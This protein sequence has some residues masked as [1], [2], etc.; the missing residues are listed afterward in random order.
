MKVI[1]KLIS[2]TLLISFSTLLNAAE[3]TGIVLPKH[4][5]ELTLPID[6]KISEL[7]LKEGDNISKE[8]KILKLDDSLQVL[9]TKR[10]ELLYKDR[11]LINSLEKNENLLKEMLGSSKNLYEKTK[12]V[13]RDEVASL[14]IKYYELQGQMLAT[15]Q[16]KLIEEIEYKISS[17]ILKSHTLTSPIDG[18][19]TKINSDIG[20]WVKNG[21][22]I[23][24]VVDYKECFVEFN[25][26]EKYTQGLKIGSNLPIKIKKADALVDKNSE[27][28]F[29]SPVADKSSSLIRIKTKLNNQDLDIVPGLSAF[30]YV[31]S[32]NSND[33]TT[34]N[35]TTKPNENKDGMY[36]LDNAPIL[37][38]K[39]IIGK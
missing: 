9:D 37:K 14:E 25:I 13:S 31:Q 21:Q 2:S 34:P 20:E 5:L 12:S 39:N 27:I 35:T 33:L 22:T 15:K 28:V 7:F 24:E 18:K 26:E 17:E 30:V 10:K 6:G 36:T 29:I 32:N 23:V 4:H 8:Q 38:D 11:S 19:I 16:K 3:F 1:N